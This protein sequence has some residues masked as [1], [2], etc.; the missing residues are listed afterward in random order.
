MTLSNRIGL[1][2]KIA[3]PFAITLVAILLIGSI[4]FITT[5]S[6]IDNSENL[7]ERLVPAISEILNADRDLYQALVAQMSYIDAV[8]NNRNGE[9]QEQSFREN[10]QQALDRMN[11]ARSRLQDQSAEQKL[12]GFDQAY[13]RW[14]QLAEQSMVLARNGNSAEAKTLLRG[15][16][17]QRF[18]ELRDY[19]DVLGM[20]ADE[21]AQAQILHAVD[22]GRNH[23]VVTVVVT[24]LAL[25]LGTFLLLIFLRL[26]IRSIGQL[27]DQLD[28]IAR[29]EGDLTQRVPI[30]SQ[31]D[32]GQLAFSFNQVLDNLQTMIRT[33]QQLAAELANGAKELEA[34]AQDNH[35]GVTRQSD[36]ITTVAT[37]INQM[38][39]AIEE[40]AGSASSAS[41]LTRRTQENATRGA[42]IV[43]DS[44]EQ[45]QRLSEQIT[46]AVD[47]ISELAK[48][49]DN[50]SA[51]LDVIRNIA[52]QTNL[53]ALNAAIEAARA[54]DQGRGF[55]VVADEVRTLARRTQ[56]STEDIQR[57]ISALQ[58]GVSNIVGIME[59]GVEQA[60]DT[61]RLATEA[62]SELKAIV[63]IMGDLS[64]A[65]IGVASA[66]EQ[67]TQVI[68]EI[69]R[70]VTDINDLA[71]QGAERSHQLTD[72]SQSLTGFASQL[73][74]QTGQFRV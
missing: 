24:A 55:A 72:I 53:L 63:A 2:T 41:E 14:L 43:Q 17:A 62:D 16:A 70:T 61:E 32:L 45:V 54:G 3:L 12:A 20:V 38:Q 73:H 64:D 50:I 4:S 21:Q 40:V 58:G 1:R 22:T 33:I 65:N 7:A 74:N 37:A 49:S 59:S 9:E 68:E 44:S 48:D 13:R 11:S 29:G 25:A 19:Y 15:E 52:E 34:S 8:E 71:S 6:L 56:E 47:V 42:T 23:T 39:S 57:M 60:T 30:E 46:K 28:N 36:A 5:R 26:I 35:D 31:D 10:A 67:Q 66:T 27:R 69:N 18:G 51:V